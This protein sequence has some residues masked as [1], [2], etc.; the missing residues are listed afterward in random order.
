[1]TDIDPKLKSIRSGDTL[2]V[3]LSE[4]G[5]EIS[6]LLRRIARTIRKNLTVTDH[7]LLCPSRNE[8]SHGSRH[9]EADRL[10]VIA[11]KVSKKVASLLMR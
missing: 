6:A 9:S 10:V 5:L 7:L 8:L 11:G 3:T 1:M 2:D 4:F